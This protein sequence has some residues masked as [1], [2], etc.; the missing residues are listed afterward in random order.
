VTKLE[1]ELEQRPWPVTYVGDDISALGYRLA[2]VHV[3]VAGGADLVDVFERAC[4]ESRVVLVSFGLA[5]SLP[6]DKLERARA[7]SSPLILILPDEKS[8]EE[9]QDPGARARAALGMS[10]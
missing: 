10:R 3:E 8:G 5:V 7:A 1:D 4:A 2:G 6:Q 9:L